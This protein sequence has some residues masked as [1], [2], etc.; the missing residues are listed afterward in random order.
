[1]FRVLALGSIG[2]TVFL[3]GFIELIW[4]IEFWVSG[5]RVFSMVRTYTSSVVVIGGC[6]LRVL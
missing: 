1:M 4:F 3:I 5:A 2:Y 6:C